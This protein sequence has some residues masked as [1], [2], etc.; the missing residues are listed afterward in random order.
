MDDLTKSLEFTQAKVADQ[1]H[2]V[3]QHESG[4]IKNEAVIKQLNEN[5]RVSGIVIKGLE[6]RWDYQVDY[7]R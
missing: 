3:K 1:Q 5:L 6:E 2:Q 7:S 4:K